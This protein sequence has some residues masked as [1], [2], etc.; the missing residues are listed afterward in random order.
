MWRTPERRC[1]AMGKL[2]KFVMEGKGVM[3][4]RSDRANT[5]LLCDRYFMTVLVI[6][7]GGVW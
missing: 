3:K 6:M 7:E 1:L 4:D 2:L 5:V